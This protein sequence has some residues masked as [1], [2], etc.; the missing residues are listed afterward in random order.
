MRGGTFEPGCSRVETVKT[1]TGLESARST[2]RTAEKSRPAAA[3]RRRWN[4]LW[5]RRWYR[6][7]YSGPGEHQRP[8]CD[9]VRR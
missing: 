3:G 4:R 6:C 7:W 1:V 9:P 2:K 8:H 5:N